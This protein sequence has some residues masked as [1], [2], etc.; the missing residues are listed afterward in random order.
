MERGLA[1]LFT[2]VIVSTLLFL[3]VA[4]VFKTDTPTIA[5][6]LSMIV[7]HFILD[8]NEWVIDSFVRGLKWASK[9]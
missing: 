4:N 5:Y 8:K 2:L 1:Y 7:G 9:Q 6:L 3:I